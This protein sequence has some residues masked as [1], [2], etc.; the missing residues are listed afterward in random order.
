[1]TNVTTLTAKAGIVKGFS[2]EKGGIVLEDNPNLWYNYATDKAFEQ[3]K[4]KGIVRG[5]KIVLFLN[6]DG[7]YDEVG[8]V[9]APK[10][11]DTPTGFKS[12]YN[13]FESKK[14]VIPTEEEFK[15]RADFMAKAW[16][17]ATDGI[18]DNEEHLDKESRTKL[19]SS[20]FIFLTRN[21]K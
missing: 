19:V 21:E 7:K 11:R 3:A 2:K 14:W 10:P 17:I 13:K 16:I 12:S 8:D 15:K 4:T 18:I 1:M 6:E 20:R 9:E 5:S